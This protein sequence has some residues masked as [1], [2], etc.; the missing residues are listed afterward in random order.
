MGTTEK[1]D[2]ENVPIRKGC[3][4]RSDD[5]HPEGQSNNVCCLPVCWSPHFRQ[6]YAK[7]VQD[8]MGHCWDTVVTYELNG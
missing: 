6:G 4:G 5:V 3:G 1:D 7:L 8:H 2:D